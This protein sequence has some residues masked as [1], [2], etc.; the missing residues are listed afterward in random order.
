M[1]KKIGISILFLVIVI[2]CVYFYIKI[3]PPLEIST[4]AS[5]TDNKSIVI[6]VGN[7]GFR[8]VHIVDVSV[9]NDEKPM[10]T[11]LQ[12]SNALQGFI[13]ADDDTD[14]KAK[15]YGFT[16]IDHATIKTGTSPSSNF[17]KL[18]DGTATENDEIYGISIFHNEKVMEIQIKYSYLGLSFDETVTFY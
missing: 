17:E 16:N 3:N 8:E 2:G 6:G 7:T 14:E 1:K 9:N 4:L 10:K 13:I 11:K 15:K 12:V 18:D 5:S